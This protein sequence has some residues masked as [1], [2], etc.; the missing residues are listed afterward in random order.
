MSKS[1]L[2]TASAWQCYGHPGGC[3]PYG[4]LRAPVSGPLPDLQGNHDP[5]TGDERGLRITPPSC[6]AAQGC[7]N[8]AT[9]AGVLQLPQGCRLE[10]QVQGVSRAS[11]FCSLSPWLIWPAPP[12]VFT[13][14][15]HHVPL[16]PIPPC[17]KDTGHAGLGPTLASCKVGS[18]KVLLL[19]ALTKATRL[20]LISQ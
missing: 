11:F 4:K 19:F 1:G 6:S 7:H 2:M 9:Q 18:L 10:G 14:C 3:H 8:K 16:Y 12:C 13:S 15:S 5:G 20:D 17:D